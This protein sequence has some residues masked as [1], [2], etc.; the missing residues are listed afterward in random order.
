MALARAAV[1]SQ[2]ARIDNF[3]LLP[4]H[5]AKSSLTGNPGEFICGICVR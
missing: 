5:A 4:P 2:Q 3:R 1:A